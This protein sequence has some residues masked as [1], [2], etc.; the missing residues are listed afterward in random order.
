MKL[1]TKDVPDTKAHVEQQVEYGI[2]TPDGSVTWNVA[3]FGSTA[4]SLKMVVTGE[5]PTFGGDSQR[6]RFREGVMRK[7]NDLGVDYE[8]YLSDLKFITRSIVISVLEPEQ[9]NNP[10]FPPNPDVAF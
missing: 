4:L 9:V 3:V 1:E 6:E 2:V 5:S 10:F 8:Q 7:C